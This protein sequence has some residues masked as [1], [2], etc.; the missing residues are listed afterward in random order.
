MVKSVLHLETTAWATLNSK[1]PWNTSQLSIQVP[2]MI[3]KS[4]FFCGLQNLYLADA[5]AAKI[6]KDCFPQA[7]L[8]SSEWKSSTCISPAIPRAYSI[9][10]PAHSS[11]GQAGCSGLQEQSLA[12]LEWLPAQKLQRCLALPCHCKT[13]SSLLTMSEFTSQ[14]AFILQI[15]GLKK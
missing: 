6:L 11:P 4:T 9:Q 7:S 12:F 13:P 3:H 14:A 2:D 15:H 8:S 5:P 10:E 1:L